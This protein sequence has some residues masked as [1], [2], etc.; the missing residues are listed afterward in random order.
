[1]KLP[2]GSSLILLLFLLILAVNCARVIYKP[3]LA[4]GPS[5]ARWVEKTMARM[6]LEEKIGQM[7]SWR[8]NGKFVNW[9]VIT[10]RALSH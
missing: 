9:I 4:F 2:K 3:R 8:Y 10:S 5:G 1:M 7:V 6:T